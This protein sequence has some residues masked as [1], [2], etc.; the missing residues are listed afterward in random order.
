MG[1]ALTKKKSQNSLPVRK[2]DSSTK[3]SAKKAG[4]RPTGKS[5]YACISFPGRKFFKMSSGVIKTRMVEL[6]CKYSNTHF[7]LVLEFLNDLI[8][9]RRCVYNE[10]IHFNILDCNTFL[11]FIDEK[12]D[13][14]ELI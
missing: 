10:Q 5:A 8:D 6:S 2:L 7:Y 12:E 11:D 1:G 9:T 13:Y 4:A 3:E 14:D